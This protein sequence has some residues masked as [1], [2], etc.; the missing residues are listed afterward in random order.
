MKQV[1]YHT[2]GSRSEPLNTF[3]PCSSV[4]LSA[5]EVYLKPLSDKLQL[6]CFLLRQCLVTFACLQV[7]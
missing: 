7:R 3:E 4:A 1:S 6:Y 2:A 5:V